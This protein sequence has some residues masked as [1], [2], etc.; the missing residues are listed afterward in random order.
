MT[1][2]PQCYEE[3]SIK[4]TGRDL[5]ATRLGLKTLLAA[6][7]RHEHV[8]H[9]IHAALAKLP[10]AHQPRGDSCACVV[11]GGAPVTAGRTPQPGG[12]S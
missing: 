3:I 11:G 12:Q 5:W 9:D 7:T 6:S 4:L 2:V 8:Y 1:A 10:H